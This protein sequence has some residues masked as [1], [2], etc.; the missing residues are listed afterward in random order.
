[1]K[2][3]TIL[4]SIAVLITTLL[5]IPAG[6]VGAAKPIVIGAFRSEVLIASMDLV[7]KYKVPNWEP[8]PRALGFRKNS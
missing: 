1:M 2:K 5:I 4:F 3:G 8:S 7:S 6:P